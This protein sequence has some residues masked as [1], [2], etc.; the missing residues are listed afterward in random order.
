MSSGENMTDCT[1]AYTHAY[2]CRCFI[3][4]LFYC[5]IALLFYCFI[6]LL[7]YCF[8]V[9]LSRH[10]RNHE[11]KR[12]SVAQNLIIGCRFFF[13]SVFFFSYFFLCVCVF[14]V[15]CCDYNKTG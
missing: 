10:S 9:L 12:K 11:T 2:T 14:F 8:I 1:R 15:V 6:V 13:T 3:V 4:L 5:F 7:F